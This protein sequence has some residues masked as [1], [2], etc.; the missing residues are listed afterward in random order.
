MRSIVI[1]GLLGNA[2]FRA[3]LR[4]SACG[5]TRTEWECEASDTTA[6]GKVMATRKM[7]TEAGG[8][9]LQLIYW[10]IANAIVEISMA[11]V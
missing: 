5:I 2:R 4:I 6:Q 11:T 3:I 1:S 9:S 10:G 8:T 7:R